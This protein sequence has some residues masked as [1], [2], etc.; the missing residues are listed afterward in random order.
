MFPKTLKAVES[1]EFNYIY[2]WVTENY[3]NDDFQ[4]RA[5][6]YIIFSWY[7]WQ[8]ESKSTMSRIHLTRIYLQVSSPALKYL[9]ISREG[10]IDISCWS[11]NCAYEVAMELHLT[12]LFVT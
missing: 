11:K 6:L 3:D 5:S 10:V 9:L 8:K 4:I 1:M 2:F 7:S 12:R